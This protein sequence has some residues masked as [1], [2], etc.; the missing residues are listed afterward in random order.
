MAEHLDAT[1]VAGRQ[2]YLE[3]YWGFFPLERMRVLERY[4]EPRNLIRKSMN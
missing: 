4:W 3:L 2:K 1:Q